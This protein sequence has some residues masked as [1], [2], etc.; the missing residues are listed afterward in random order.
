VIAHVVR[1]SFE[2]FTSFLRHTF[3]SPRCWPGVVLP[4]CDIRPFCCAPP[5][6]PVRCGVVDV[7]FHRVVDVGVVRCWCTLF[8]VRST[9]VYLSLL[10]LFFCVATTICCYM[11]AL[12]NYICC[13]CC[14]RY[15]S[16]WLPLP[17]AH[18]LFVPLPSGLHVHVCILLPFWITFSSRTRGS[19]FTIPL[20]RLYHTYSSYAAH[21]RLHLAT[22]HLRILTIYS[23]T[24]VAPYIYV[25]HLRIY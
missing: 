23:I 3:Y 21:R 5:T 19:Q 1:C 17:F 20:L 10:R 11:H 24:P 4:V 18:S 16:C 15:C 14:W 25:T 8:V 22:R 7:T 6:L 2:N 12:A 9:F 13:C